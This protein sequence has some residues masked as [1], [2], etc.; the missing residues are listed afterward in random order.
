MGYFMTVSEAKEFVGKTVFV[1][2]VDRN[3]LPCSGSGK[4]YD[5]EYVPMYG[6][7]L[8]FDFGDVPLDKV[9]LLT[10]EAVRKAA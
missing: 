5:V 6:S 7:N 3:G 9:C 1:E 10:D 4:L 2:Y 8:V